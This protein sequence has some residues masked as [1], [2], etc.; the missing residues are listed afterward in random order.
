MINKTKKGILQIKEQLADANGRKEQNLAALKNALVLSQKEIWAEILNLGKNR[1]IKHLITFLRTVGGSSN[2]IASSYLGLLTS[3]IPLSKYKVPKK[4]SENETRILS[5]VCNNKSDTTFSDKE[6]FK[7]IYCDR[8]RAIQY[9]THKSKLKVKKTEDVTIILISG[10]FN[11][12]FTTAAFE[13]GAKHLLDRYEIEYLTPKTSGI[14]GHRHNCKLLKDQLEK[15]I[16][17][18]PRKK[19]WLIGYSK[20]GTD[21]LYFIRKH[22]DF[23]RKYILGLSTIASPIL[24]TDHFNKRIIKLLK[25]TGLSKEFFHL[26]STRREGWFKRNYHELPEELFY[27]SI[28]FVSDWHEG[29]YSMMI[30]RTLLSIDGPND[31]MVCVENAHFPEYFKA[32]NLGE[33]KGHHLSGARGSSY[34]QEALIEALIIFLNYKDKMNSK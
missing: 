21:A 20:G 13:K 26:D 19:L 11:E 23:S 27:T 2:W 7:A 15:Y 28:A 8:N 14:K 34:K 18:N 25:N 29:H 22:Q 17:E 1:D 33:V 4:T 16:E 9:K 3:P 31:G 24:G 30:A 12:L 32:I 5:S 6:I 10:V